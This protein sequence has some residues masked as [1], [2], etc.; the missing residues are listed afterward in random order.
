MR[1]SFARLG[2][3][4]AALTL[5]LSLG[6]GQ[7]A[8]AGPDASS[9]A[10]AYFEMTDITRET[11]TVRLTDQAKIDRARRI[12]S[13]QERE[14]IHVIGRIVKRP[15]PWNPRWSFHYDPA[16]VDFFSY[17]IEACDSTIPYTEDH[18]DEAGG[19]FLPGLVWCPWT[20]TLV[21]ELPA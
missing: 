5:A 11:F 13:G 1:R 16:T 8:V 19:P 20:S 4:G 9:E 12:L 7:G 18:L 3:V 15:A 21:R 17:A 14:E 6:A 10:A 2:A